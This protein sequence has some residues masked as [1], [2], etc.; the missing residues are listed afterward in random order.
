[1]LVQRGPRCGSP[2]GIV[3]EYLRGVLEHDQRAGGAFG[4]LPANI[5]YVGKSRD[6]IEVFSVLTMKLKYKIPTIRPRRVS[7][8]IGLGQQTRITS[9]LRVDEE[10]AF[11]A[12]S[13]THNESGPRSTLS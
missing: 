11:L 4:R 6:A 1:M 2:S 3:L 9:L 10:S 7:E 8:K 5:E 12:T 13:T